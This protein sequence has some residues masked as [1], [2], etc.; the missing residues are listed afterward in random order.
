MSKLAGLQLTKCCVSTSIYLFKFSF[1]ILA[2]GRALDYRS[3]IDDFVAKNRDLR[4]Y[5]MYSE[6]WDAIILVARWLK[7]FRS[8]TTQMSGTKRSMLSSTHAIFRGLQESLRESLRTLPDNT[9]ARLKLG[10]TRAHRKLSDYYGKI[11]DSPYYTWSSRER[12]Y[13]LF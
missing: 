2:P 13:L 1:L 6:D 3:I 9:P 8:A 5:E 4:K 11:D 7:S 10:L 12:S